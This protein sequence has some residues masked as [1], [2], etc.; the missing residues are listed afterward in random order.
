M[1]LDDSENNVEF[2]RE[3]DVTRT[4]AKGRQYKFEATKEEKSALAERYSIMSI[5]RLEAECFIIPVKKKQYKLEAV[6][7]AHVVQSCGLSLEPI[8][9]KIS[10][11]YTIII[12]QQQMHR[13][14]AEVDFSLDEEDVEFLSS[15]IIDMGEMIAQH[16]SLEINPYPRKQ[17]ATGEELGQKIIKED[18]MLLELKKKNPFEVLKSLKHKT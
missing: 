15:D 16:L 8:E 18:D 13:E 4:P 11:K 3:V 14:N 2:S 5:E 12:Q 6:L 7:S 17:D 1:P 9:E 10:S